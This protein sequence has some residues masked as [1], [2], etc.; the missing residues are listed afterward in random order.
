VLIITG[1]H[2][3]P[4]SLMAHSWHPVPVLMSAPHLRGGDGESFDEV[5]CRRGQIG[6]IPSKEIIPLAMAHAGK[7][8]KFGA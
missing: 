6:T 8:E 2:S 3:T 5:N 4:P 1:D 7:L